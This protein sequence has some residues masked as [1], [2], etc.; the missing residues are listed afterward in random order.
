MVDCVVT[1]LFA[2]SVVFGSRAL[3]WIYFVTLS[4]LCWCHYEFSICFHVNFEWYCFHVN[5]EWYN[6]YLYLIAHCLR[7]NEIKRKKPPQ[8]QKKTPRTHFGFAHH[9]MNTCCINVGF[10]ICNKGFHLYYSVLDEKWK[11]Q[12]YVK[13]QKS[14]CHSIHRSLLWNVFVASVTMKW[15]ETIYPA[16]ICLA[17]DSLPFIERIRSNHADVIAPS[18]VLI[19]AKKMTTDTENGPSRSSDETAWVK[20]APLAWLALL[21]NCLQNI[22]FAL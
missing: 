9:V 16:L 2:A 7:I 8:E 20:I 13:L 10:V 12:S 21:D 14:Q 5:F 19:F 3:V 15:I 11:C 17:C 4:F 18:L 22:A 1:S 6:V